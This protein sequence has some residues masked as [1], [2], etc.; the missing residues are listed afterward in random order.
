MAEGDTKKQ[1]L[2]RD[3]SMTDDKPT[4][5]NYYVFYDTIQFSTR[6][7]FYSK[8]YYFCCYWNSYYNPDNWESFCEMER[9]K[10]C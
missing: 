6:K 9:E 4:L 5:L 3:K 1:A 8:F 7:Y 10:K 2:L